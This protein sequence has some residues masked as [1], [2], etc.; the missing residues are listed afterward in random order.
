MVVVIPVTNQTGTGG[1]M[2]YTNTAVQK[3]EYY[4]VQS[5]PAP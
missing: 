5:E 3:Q 1:W 2:G 4:R